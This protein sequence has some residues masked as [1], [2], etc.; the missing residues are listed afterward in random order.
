M[1][2]KHRS[3]SL[4]AA[5]LFTTLVIG[6]AVT[7]AAAFAQGL[8]A[9]LGESRTVTTAVTVKSVD[10]TTRHLVVA[11]PS[12]EVFSLK[13]PVAL[14]NFTA[15][16]VG[17]TIKDTYTRE[18]EFA[19]SAPNAPLPPNIETTI[20]ARSESGELPAGLVANHLVVTGAIVAIDPETHTL[21]LVDP[22]GGQVHAVHV[23][24]P[25]R[26]RAFAQLKVGDTITAYVSESLLV[27][28]KSK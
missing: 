6:L 9:G 12:G 10:I 13:A 27:S 18:T 23:R 25:D 11:G 3:K 28:V 2:S 8:L 7:P 17:D 4:L 5:A 24:N 19:L 22:K 16:K 15:I 1:I 21:K 14:E 20:A 26:Q